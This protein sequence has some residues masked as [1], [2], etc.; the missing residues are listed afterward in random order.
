MRCTA[1]AVLLLAMCDPYKKNTARRMTTGQ[2]EGTFLGTES[3]F[4]GDKLLRG[5]IVNRTKYCYQ[6]LLVKMVKYM[7]G[8]LCIPQVILTTI[9]NRTKYCYQ[10][11]L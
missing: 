4:F 1:A 10:V 9:V 6:V 2:V 8:F 11:L 7:V 3:T 5:S